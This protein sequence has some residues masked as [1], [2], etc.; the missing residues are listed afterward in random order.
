MSMTILNRIILKIFKKIPKTCAIISIAV[1]LSISFLI[2]NGFCTDLALSPLNIKLTKEEEVWL[3]SNRMIKI[4][5]PRAFPPFHYFDGNKKLN[6]ISAEY[7][8]AIMNQLKV[9][10]EI[11]HDLP[12]MEVLDKAK[13][14]TIDLIPCIAKTA[15]RDIFL[16]FTKPYLSFPLVIISNKNAP[17]IGG[18]E[19]LYGKTIAMVRQNAIISWLKDDKIRFTPYYVESPLKKLEAV[20]F[21]RV[22][23]T[24]EN[25]AAASYL[26]Q[27]NGLTNIKI[28]A[29]TPYGKYN[30]YMAVREDLPELLGI[31]NKAIDSI[32]PE[33]HMQIRDKWLSV[34]YEHGIAKADILKWIS[35]IVAISIIIVIMVVIR[36]KRLIRENAARAKIIGELKHAL[37]EIE[38][39]RGI[40][41]ICSYCKQIRDDKGYWNQI[42]SYI[43]K[44]SEADFSHSICPAC[45]KKHFP[46]MDI[47]EE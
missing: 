5:G 33:Q 42:E 28:A 1:L 25:L 36:N 45:A 43:K 35:I 16:N 30:L 9:K 15:D 27:K 47:Y 13:T 3:K 7:I 8:F 18:I 41:P 10:L 31:L 40:L 29:P 39:L 4:G 2:R 32:T 46:D 44:H 23:A 21:G 19:D 14:G 26:I 17:F 37:D 38:T 24:I 6:G 12:W 20:S 34:R 11:Q 22:D